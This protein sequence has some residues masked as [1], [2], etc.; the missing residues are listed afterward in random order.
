MTEQVFCARC[1]VGMPLHAKFCGTCGDRME[2]PRVD[3]AAPSGGVARAAIDRGLETSVTR[4]ASA[5]AQSAYP[6]ERS[7]GTGRRVLSGIG[8]ATAVGSEIVSRLMVG[9]L[10]VGVAVFAFSQGETV[11]GIVATLYAAY[12]LLLRGSWLI[13]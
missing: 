3:E 8:T 2:A 9:G 6:A 5:S 4:T 11:I 13:V 10:A 1:G 12:V 7:R